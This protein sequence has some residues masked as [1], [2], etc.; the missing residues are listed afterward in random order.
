MRFLIGRK[1][2]QRTQ[3]LENHCFGA[4]GE[5][6]SCPCCTVATNVAAPALLKCGG[7][8]MHIWQQRGPWADRSC[9]VALR[10]QS[11][12]NLLNAWGWAAENLFTPKPA[13]PRV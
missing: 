7:A 13:G 1:L 11:Y 10:A 3:C 6:G 8:G 5:T 4:G 9:A 2:F 12:Q